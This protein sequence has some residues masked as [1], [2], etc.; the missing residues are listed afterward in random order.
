[1]EYDVNQHSG[2]EQT[3]QLA[4]E[5][6]KEA[7]LLIPNFLKLLYRLLKNP[8]ISTADKALLAGTVAYVLSPVDFLPDM[9]PFL[10]QVDDILLVA[11]VVKRLMDSVS[12]DVLEE[13][14][15]GNGR[16]LVWIEQVISLS[17]YVVPPKIYNRVVKKSRA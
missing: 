1:M 9:V 7:L 14:W 17:R 8:A 2:S 11:L 12:Y 15:D 10:G 16:L 5:V 6:L 3:H 13:Y 4:E